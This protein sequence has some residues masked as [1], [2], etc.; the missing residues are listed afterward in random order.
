M[1]REVCPDKHDFLS[2]LPSDAS[3]RSLGRTFSMD[4]FMISCWACW[5]SSVARES[6]GAFQEADMRLWSLSQLLKQQHN[7]EDPSLRAEATKRFK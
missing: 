3:A 1:I 4:A 7:G 2:H 5:F 6:R